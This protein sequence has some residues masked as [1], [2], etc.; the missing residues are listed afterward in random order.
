M[1]ERNHSDHKY[2]EIFTH[3]VGCIGAPSRTAFVRRTK[4]KRR[5]VPNMASRD[6]KTTKTNIFQEGSAGFKSTID[7]NK[8]SASRRCRRVR[9]ECRLNFSKANV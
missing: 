3:R 6:T 9:R 8:K 4:A 1:I 7:L 5:E 2:V